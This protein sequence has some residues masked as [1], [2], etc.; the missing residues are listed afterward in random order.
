MFSRNEKKMLQTLLNSKGLVVTYVRLSDYRSNYD[1]RLS[2]KLSI[3]ITIIVSISAARVVYYFFLFYHISVKFVKSKRG[4]VVSSKERQIYQNCHKCS[5][6]VLV[7][8]V[9]YV[10]QVFSFCVQNSRKCTLCFKKL[11]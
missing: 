5:V 7:E 1:K 8:L 3:V 6:E 2:K 9:L 4:S 11:F 10:G